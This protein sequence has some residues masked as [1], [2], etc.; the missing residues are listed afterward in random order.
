MSPLEATA[1][2]YKGND[3]SSAS[4]FVFRLS[5]NVVLKVV[6]TRRTAATPEKKRFSRGLKTKLWSPVLD[7][8]VNGL[9]MIILLL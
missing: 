6:S 2:S 8:C 1:A 3:G 5:N 7:R 9:A 4:R